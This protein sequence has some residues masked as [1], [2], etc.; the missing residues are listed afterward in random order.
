MGYLTVN[1][2]YETYLSKWSVVNRASCRCHE[3]VLYL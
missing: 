3:N 1:F 2:L